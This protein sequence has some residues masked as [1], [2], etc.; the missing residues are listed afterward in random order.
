VNQRNPNSIQEAHQEAMKKVFSR[1]ISHDPHR[2]ENENA[3]PENRL[4]IPCRAEQRSNP[5]E[6]SKR[7][8]GEKPVSSS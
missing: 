1:G 6:N 3:K 2:V 8:E 7:G 4:D 5:D